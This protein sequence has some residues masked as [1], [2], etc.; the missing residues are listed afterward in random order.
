MFDHEPLV[1]I[2][3]PTF[4]GSRYIRE[5]IQ[6]CLDQTHAHLELIIMDDGSRDNTVQIIRSFQDPRLKL[7]SLEKNQGHIHALNQGF[8]VSQGEY[9]TWTSDDNYYAPQAIKRMLE[10]LTGSKADFVYSR[11]NVI[12][13]SGNILRQGRSEDPAYLDID[14]CVGGCFLYRRK[15]YETIGDFNQDAFLAEDY[16]Y[17]LRVRA[18]FKMQKIDVVFY[19]YREHPQSLTGVNKEEKVQEQVQRIRKRFLP[20]YKRLYFYVKQRLRR[21]KPILPLFL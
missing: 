7:I 19:S 12:D 9:L 16:E 21:I 1:S 20:F 5:S 15:V 11:Y 6:S 8:A 10:E 4:N 2:I 13:E 3:L 14:N 18:K 17:W